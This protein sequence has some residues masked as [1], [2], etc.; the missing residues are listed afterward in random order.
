[1]TGRTSIPTDER[2]LTAPCGL[3]GKPTDPPLREGTSY[4][5][6]CWYGPAGRFG[7]RLPAVP[8]DGWTRCG[9][10]GIASNSSH[11]GDRHRPTCL[12]FG[13]NTWPLAVTHVT[14]NPSPVTD[15]SEVTSVAVT[16]L[17]R[18]CLGEIGPDRRADAEYCSDAHKVAAYRKGRLTQAEA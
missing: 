10:C 15:R 3:C 11:H 1:M 12:Q 7:K 5:D 2:P 17:C 8:I 13:D 6:A 4:C 9:E 16:R 18:H 14:D